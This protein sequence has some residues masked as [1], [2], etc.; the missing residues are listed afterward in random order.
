MPVNAPTLAAA[1]ARGASAPASSAAGGNDADEQA[2]AN[3]TRWV[4]G[5]GGLL[6]ESHLAVSGMW[7]AACAPT[8]EQALR[9]VT[10]VHDARV[11]AAASRAVVRWDPAQANLHDL[12]SA[13]QRAGY[14][15][16]PDG[17]V[18]PSAVRRRESRMALWRFF[19]AGF[20][21]MQVMMFLTPSYVSGPGDLDDDMR[22]L[23]AWGAWT[24]TLPVLAFAATPFF[25]GAW[26]AVRHRR[27]GM[28]VPVALGLIVTFVA[29]TA[30]MVDPSGPF[31]REVYFDSLTMFVAFLLG[32]R[33]LETRARH[34]AAA[35]LED[36]AQRLPDA[37]RRVLD[38]GT[39]E[40]VPAYRLRVGDRLRVPMGESFAADG[41]LLDAG[42]EV[43]EA[44]LTGESRPVPRAV[45]ANVL[46]GSVNLGRSVDLRVH[47]VGA[48]TRQAGI[49]ALMREA[50]LQRPEVARLA[51][52]WAVPF[53]WA[54]LGL[55]AGSALVWSVVEP[56][57]AVWVA[58]SVLIVTCPCALSLAVPSAQLAATGYLARYG[59]LLRRVD[60]LEALARVGRMVFDKTGTLTQASGTLRL[61][62]EAMAGSAVD[63]AMLEA[64]RVAAA[65]AG[66][67]THPVSRAIVAAA[68]AAAADGTT[69]ACFDI[70]EVAGRGLRGRD[71]RGRRWRLGARGW[72]TGH[73]GDERRSDGSDRGG[74][75]VASVEDAA[76]DAAAMAWLSD[77]VRTWRFVGGD[78]TLR[79]GAQ[80]LGKSLGD[81]GVELAVVSGDDQA[82]VDAVARRVGAAHAVARADPESKLEM[83]EAWQREGVVVA[84]VGDGVNDAPGIARADVSIAMGEGA[85]V[86]RGQADAVL[87]GDDL[88][89]LPLALAHAR[90]TLRV[91]RQNL[92]WA[93]VYNLACVPLAMA[94]WLPPW[95]AGLGMAAS[96]L[97]VI[98]NAQ[99]LLR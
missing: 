80:A 4:D 83:L 55:A 76:S 3:C 20:C 8:V 85:S 37:A 88:S 77:G 91:V 95:A 15:A 78:E 47:A 96:S 14:T 86:T 71:A 48:D 97:A 36:A 56:S 29:S 68:P 67:S 72:V 28:D 25:A 18:A 57:R 23:L 59:L 98:A 30:A 10:G 5:E 7:C 16:T 53:L 24:L 40:T 51:D 58:V 73:E 6:A 61:E 89:V 74:T 41:V 64:W 44:I 99:R 1:D 46:A 45:G 60:A 93:A 32:A 34:R 70:H 31:G 62:A 13:V 94:G 38:D 92:A 82:R 65:L 52:R 63:D 87:I 33:W 79:H 17:V 49:V 2:L 21:S 81:L 26:R 42:T 43:D 22:R 54:V 84:M 19:V 27:I 69:T 9:G 35:W 75:T 50:A 66:A 12:A 11:S 90:R 39:V